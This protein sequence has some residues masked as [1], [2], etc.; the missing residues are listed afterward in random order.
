MPFTGCN[1]PHLLLRNPVALPV[2]Y[3]FTTGALLT[4]WGG[5]VCGVA[6]WFVCSVVAALC[7]IVL[8]VCSVAFVLDVCVG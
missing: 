1:E 2:Y 5:S 3:P 7:A 4:V 8:S 6:M